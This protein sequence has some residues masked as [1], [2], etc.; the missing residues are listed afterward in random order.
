MVWIWKLEI[1]EYFVKKW[2]LDK[3]LAQSNQC[4]N[5][6]CETCKSC[7]KRKKKRTPPLSLLEKSWL[8][9]ASQTLC[10]HYK[11]S[12]NTSI[13]STVGVWDHQFNPFMHLEK[14]WLFRNSI[15]SKVQRCYLFPKQNCWLT[16][17]RYQNKWN[18]YFCLDLSYIN[19]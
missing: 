12:P 6:Y 4:W 18:V 10:R 2:A 14:H 16:L 15:A 11:R 3:N 5:P 9:L 1:T 19:S 7:F 17:Q 13:I 8:F